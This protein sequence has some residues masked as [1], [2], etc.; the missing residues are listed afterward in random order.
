MVWNPPEEI[1]KLEAVWMPYKNEILE[2]QLDKVPKEVLEAYKKD[3][4]WAWE[5]DQ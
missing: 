1:K 3:C 4:E 5:Q 2:G